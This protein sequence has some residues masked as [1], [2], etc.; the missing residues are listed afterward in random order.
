[1]LGTF[2]Q[3]HLR[4]EIDASAS[5]IARSLLHPSELQKWLP[6][7]LSPGLPEKLHEG[8]TFTSSLG[9]V[10]IEHHVEVASDRCLRM[11]L[12]GGIDGFHEWYWGDGWVQSRLEGVSLLP[13]NLGQTVSLWRLKEFLA[14]SK[15]P[16]P[17]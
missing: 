1:M 11:L 6:Q 16:Q 14:A 5:A 15:E 4:I 12:S 13:L 9:F 10:S 2:Q 17:Q 7:Q 8:L 3:S